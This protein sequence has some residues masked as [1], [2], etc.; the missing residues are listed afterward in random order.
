MTV[1]PI[2][3]AVSVFRWVDLSPVTYVHWGP[4]EPNDANGEEQCVQMDRH[5][6]ALMLF[7]TRSGSF[8]LM[9]ILLYF[10]LTYHMNTEL[11]KCLT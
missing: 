5:P 2:E 4:G 6:G 9:S 10:I 1:S 3:R 8:I 7:Y 11:T